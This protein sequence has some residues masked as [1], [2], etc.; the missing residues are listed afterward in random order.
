MKKTIFI[1]ATMLMATTAFAQKGV[2]DG[3]RYGHGQDSIDVV[4]ANVR[5]TDAFKLKNYEAAYPDWLK[6]FNEAPLFKGKASTLYSQGVT[7]V[8]SLYQKEKDAAKKAE[9]FALLM[10]TY[11]QRMKYYGDNATYPTTYIKGMKALDMLAFKGDDVASMKEANELLAASLTGAPKTIQAAFPVKY[12]ENTI[13]L[14]KSQNATAEDVV[15]VYMKASDTMKELEKIQTEKNADVIADTKAQVEQRF[16]SSGAADCET[17]ANIFGPQLDANKD[18]IDW[19]RFINRL[20]DKGDCTESDLFY[21]TS[22]HMHAIEP[23]A[24]SARGLARMYMKRNDIDKSV[25]YYNQAIELETEDLSKAKYYLELSTVYFSASQFAAAKAAAYN[26]LKLRDAWG[27]PYLMLGRIYAA[28]SKLVGTDDWEK[29]AGYWVACDKF[30]K[31]K[32]VDESCATEANNLISQYRQYFPAKE[33]L[34][35]HGM[36]VGQSYSVGG[37]IGESTTIR[38]K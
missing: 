35:M 8:K 10:K 29:R 19:L 30:A 22:E 28:G 25:S 38:S 5:Y 31:A 14:F 36:Q 11:D 20:L 27:Q 32:A 13:D 17:I 7:I 4:L 6:I 15:K 37:F 21:A 16:A 2:E 9:F 26:A 1:A 24:S 33:D 23:A 34:F 12:L 3:S 18:N